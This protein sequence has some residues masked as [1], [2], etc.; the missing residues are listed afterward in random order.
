VMAFAQRTI[1]LVDGRIVDPV[2]L[3]ATQA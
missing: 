2:A 3:G 1:K